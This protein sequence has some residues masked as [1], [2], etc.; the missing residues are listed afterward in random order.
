MPTYEYQC[1]KCDHEFS[2]EQRITEKPVKKCPECGSMQAKRLIS[3]TNFV[4]K[5]SG[6]YND[7]YSSSSDK[8]ADSDGDSATEASSDSTAKDGSDKKS[9]DDSSDKGTPEKKSK[10]SSDKGSSKSGKSK[11]KGGKAAA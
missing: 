11:K 7:L 5:G 8:K 4:L 3:K 2:R 10:K 1:K 6:W 9:K